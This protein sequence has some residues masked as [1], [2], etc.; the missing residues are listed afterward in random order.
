LTVQNGG[1]ISAGTFSEGPAGDVT[2]S[3][4]NL[5]VDGMGYDGFTGI[6]SQ[7]N[8]T[9]LGDGGNVTVSVTDTLTV[10]NDGRISVR[11]FSDEGNAGELKVNAPYLTL[12]DGGSIV[13]TASDTTGGNVTI[14]ADYLKLL[15]GSE[16]SSSAGGNISNSD[17]GNVT[18]HSTNIV[19]LDGST[20]TARAEEFQGGRIRIEAQAFLHDAPT[21]D[22][23]LS[24]TGGRSGND[25]TVEVNAPTT[26]ISGSLANLNT[27]YLD[28]SHH[29]SRHC[30]SGDR[31]ER[32]HFLIHGRGA[33]PLGPDEAMPAP[34]SRCLPTEPV[35]L[36]SSA[37][38][39]R[40]DVPA[41]PVSVQ[42]PPGAEFG[43]NNR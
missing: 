41:A 35:A 2:V 10:K 27:P 7:A 22:D 9:A 17:G 13:A 38:N 15:N 34:L 24:A 28:V 19:A 5:L 32:S 40:Q 23:V 4:G 29:I 33:L 8:S 31:D 36:A 20:V 3:V 30:D 14:N 21:V 25:G 1:E 26:D 42:P 39:S 43:F 18:I 16:I 12:T 37:A 6:S 11:S